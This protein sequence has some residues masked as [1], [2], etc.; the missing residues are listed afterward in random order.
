MKVLIL[1]SM[2][3]VLSMQAVIA[4]YANLCVQCINAGNDYC[5]IEDTCWDSGTATCKSQLS[6]KFQCNQRFI[7]FFAVDIS[8]IR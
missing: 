3:F 5:S 8:L 7:Q 4:G 2:T 1:L 6:N